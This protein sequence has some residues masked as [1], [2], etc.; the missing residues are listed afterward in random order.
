[1]KFAPILDPHVRRPSPKPM[2]VDLRKAFLL[3]ILLWSIALVG[4]LCLWLLGHIQWFERASI[5]CGFG[6]VLGL[7]MLVWEH[8]DRWDY[9]RLGK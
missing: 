3:G 9:R 4:S 7:A 5:I 1:M 2:Q 6:I 8:F